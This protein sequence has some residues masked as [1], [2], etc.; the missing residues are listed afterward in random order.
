MPFFDGFGLW[1]NIIIK[2][3]YE[4]LSQEQVDELVER[5]LQYDERLRI[6][7]IRVGKPS[8]SH[9]KRFICKRCRLPL[10]YGPADYIGLHDYHPGCAEKENEAIRARN[11]STSTREEI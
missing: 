5:S 10:G 9:S 6:D 2:M 4:D 7:Q 11:L 1:G 8:K 3:K